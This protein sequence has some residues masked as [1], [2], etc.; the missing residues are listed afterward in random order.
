MDMWGV[1]S[2]WILGERYGVLMQ[3]GTSSGSGKDGPL[4]TRS[5]AVS[6]T[7]V[8]CLNCCRMC[9]RGQWRM[10]VN[11][12]TIAACVLAICQFSRVLASL[13]SIGWDH[14]A[15]WGVGFLSGYWSE[16]QG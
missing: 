14:L 12:A 3:G 10:A 4:T 6:I 8:L 15:S 13:T 5:W 11:W 7:G 9:S 2:P 16:G 1:P